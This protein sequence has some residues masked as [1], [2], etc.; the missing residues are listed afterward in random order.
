MSCSNNLKQ[1]AL[2]LHNYHSAFNKFPYSVA[3]DGS[4]TSGSAAPGPGQVRNHRGWLALLPFIEQ[5]SLYDMAD[6]NLAMGSHIRDGATG[7]ISGPLPGQPGTANDVVVST[8]VETFLCPSDSNPTTYSTTTSVHYSISPGNS[9]RLR[10][11]KPFG[12]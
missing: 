1:V 7:T 11:A 9:T 3:G 4:L 10:S 5:Q 8:P 12:P 2:G 6:M